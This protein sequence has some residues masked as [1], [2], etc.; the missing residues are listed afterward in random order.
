LW[1]RV[2][3]T[4][5]KSF[6]APS[7]I[8]GAWKKYLERVPS[9]CFTRNAGVGTIQGECAKCTFGGP[10]C[11]CGSL[12]SCFHRK[13]NCMHWQPQTGSRHPRNGHEFTEGTGH[14]LGLCM[15]VAHGGFER[16]V[17]E[18]NLEIPDEGTIPQGMGGKRGMALSVPLRGS[19]HLV[20][21]A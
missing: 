19:R 11:T 13:M 20:P 16:I 18:H 5:L 1:C 15:E 3:V 2:S 14:A 17:A 4:A 8:G 12:L 10:G 21:R 9:E 7:P 6:L